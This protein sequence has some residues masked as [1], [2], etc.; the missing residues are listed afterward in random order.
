MR[1]SGGRLFGW[2][3]PSALP[4]GT[5]ATP[6]PPCSTSRTPYVWTTRCRNSPATTAFASTQRCGSARDLI[7]LRTFDDPV[8]CAT[9]GPAGGRAAVI[10]ADN[11]IQVRDLATG[12][13]VGPTLPMAVATLDGAFGPD[14]RSLALI[15]RDGKVYIWDLE[16]GKDRE[17]EGE[18]ARRAPIPASDGPFSAR[19]ASTASSPGRTASPRSGGRG[20]TSWS[21]HRCVRAAP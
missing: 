1:N 15:G 10:G 18:A 4:G 19:T 5:K 17:L 9:L 2:T 12:E 13:A 8:I 21:R 14:G 11:G 6:S 3:L 16:T 20:R 7:Q